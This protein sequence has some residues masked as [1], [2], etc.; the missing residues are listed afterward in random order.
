MHV[1][2]GELAPIPLDWDTI[3]TVY[4]DMDGTLLDLHFDNHFWLDH[5]PR[6]YAQEKAVTMNQA[7]DKVMKH[8][9]E[10][11]GTLNWYCLDYW[12]DYLDLDVV[13]L[14]HEVAD[15][16]AVRNHVDA[17][18]DH[19]HAQGKRVVLLTNA[20]QKSVGLKFGYVNLERYFDRVI[21]SH[22]LGLPKEHQDFWVTMGAHEAVHPSHC[23]FIDDNLHVLRA[24]RDH[25]KV[26]HLLAVHQPDSKQP[27]KDT[28]EF[29]AVECYSQL[30]V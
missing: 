17:F 4:L 7:H 16:I 9:R 2:T 3:Q 8:V 12:N 1:T 18:L 30:M 21:T 14:K 11:E 29:T 6:R 19:L 28:E 23:L 27:P 20:H 22:E 26:G 13:A 25:G 10:I 5:L 24:A 15:R